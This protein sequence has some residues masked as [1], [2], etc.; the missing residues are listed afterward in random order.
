MTISE[1]GLG[2]TGTHLGKAGMSWVG[3]SYIRLIGSPSSLSL[4]MTSY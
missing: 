2:A 3:V 1:G 4:W